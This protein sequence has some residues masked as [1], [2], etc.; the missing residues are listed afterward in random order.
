MLRKNLSVSDYDIE[1]ITIEINNNKKQY[2]IR[3]ELFKFTS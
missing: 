3:S 2:M 1:I